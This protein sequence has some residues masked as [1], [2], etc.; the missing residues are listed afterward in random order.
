M[1]TAPLPI[2]ELSVPSRLCTSPKQSFNRSGDLQYSVM[3]TKGI[4]TQARMASYGYGQNGLHTPPATATDGFSGP[5]SD[6]KGKDLLLQASC[7]DNDST[8]RT[9]EKRSAN[10]SDAR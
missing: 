7:I 3:A 2:Q 8:M 10:V 1:A 4:E 9:N 5:C 6:S